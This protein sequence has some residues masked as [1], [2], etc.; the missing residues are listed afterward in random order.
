MTTGSLITVFFSI[1]APQRGQSNGS[2]P[3]MHLLNSHQVVE[4]T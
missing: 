1:S 3:Q 4:A 2:T